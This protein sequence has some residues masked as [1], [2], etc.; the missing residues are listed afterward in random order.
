MKQILVYA[1]SLSWGIIPDSRNR[2]EFH[3]RWPGKLEQL[4]CQDGSNIRII[5]D[6]LNGRRTVLEDPFKPGR[7][8]LKG[9][10]QCIEINS[11]L[12]LIIIMLGNNDFQTPHLFKASEAAQGVATLVQAIRKSP[13]EPGMPMP[14]ILLVC[15]PPIICPKGMIAA[16]F[17]G[18]ELKW[19]G[20][21]KA[22]EHIALETECDFFDAGKVITAS[23][24]DGIHL[25]LEQHQQLAVSIQPLVIDILQR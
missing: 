16:K 3:Q 10:Q 19:P 13:L 22:L 7:N 23:H 1:D 15:P 12:T 2:F 14:D 18:A 8:G 4:L 20:F 6:C 5:E 11:P 9:L 25:D 21:N 17:K 24:I